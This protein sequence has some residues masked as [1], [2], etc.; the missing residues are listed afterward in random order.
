MRR[1]TGFRNSA[2][3]ALAAALAAVP[4]HA[5]TDRERFELW[6][7]CGPVRVVA[8][9]AEQPH[10]GAAGTG[11]AEA[12]AAAAA[13]ARLRAARLH[14]G[15]A[16]PSLYVNVTVPGGAYAVTLLLFKPM[17]DLASGGTGLAVSWFDGSAGTH[18]G[19]AGHILSA[20]AENTDRFIGEYLRANAD[21]CPDLHDRP[22]L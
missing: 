5:Q 18:G 16:T 13:R 10:D 20:V 3:L 14:D 4:S 11:L 22:L 19:D 17:R 8:D 6:T 15:E 7:G 1:M 2:G 21:A 9:L 12:D